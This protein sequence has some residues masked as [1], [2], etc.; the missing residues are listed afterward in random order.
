MADGVLQFL[1]GAWVAGVHVGHRVQH[2]TCAIGAARVAVRGIYF[3]STGR[4]I[5]GQA[6]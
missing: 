5:C 6:R 4:S 2:E 3:V 1:S